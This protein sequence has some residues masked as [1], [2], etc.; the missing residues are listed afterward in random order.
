MERNRNYDKTFRKLI[1]WI[2]ALPMEERHDLYRRLICK[3]A[4]NGDDPIYEGVD[5]ESGAPF[6]GP[7]LWES[8]ADML[9]YFL[10]GADDSP[11]FPGSRRFERALRALHTG[12]RRQ[13]EHEAMLQSSR[14][15]K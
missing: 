5:P 9:G 3:V 2:D 6:F 1:R 12:L 15:S 8:V 7:P 14:A 4:Y 10:A 13:Q 11:L